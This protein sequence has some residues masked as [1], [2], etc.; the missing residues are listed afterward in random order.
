MKS[1]ALTLLFS[2]GVASGLRS[3]RQHKL[4]Q[5]LAEVGLPVSTATHTCAE[6]VNRLNSQATFDY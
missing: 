2:L 4:T 6:A 5:S 3:N 1:L